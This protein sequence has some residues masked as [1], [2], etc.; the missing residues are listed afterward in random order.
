MKNIERIRNMDTNELV[1]FLHEA[2]F[3]CAERCPDFAS[4]CLRS[5]TRDAGRDIIREWLETEN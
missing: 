2:S 1:E 5:C 3:D 4:G